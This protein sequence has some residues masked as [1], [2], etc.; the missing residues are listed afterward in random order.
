MLLFVFFCFMIRRPPRSTL[1]PYTTL[2]RSDR[3]KTE[4]VSETEFQKVKNQFENDFY[5]SN[6]SVAGKAESLA[7]Y[8]VF[9]NDANL[10]NKQLEVYEDI[11]REDLMKV[12][13]QY[14]KKDARV[15][16]YYLPKQ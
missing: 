8:H 6:S 12:A 11:T 10:I 1:F 13:N 14:L 7:N 2:F 9:Y 16:L 4:L 5:S 15:V 3:A